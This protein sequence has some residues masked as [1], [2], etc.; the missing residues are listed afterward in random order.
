MVEQ[1]RRAGAAAQMWP[2]R[3]T[4]SPSEL[5]RATGVSR[6]TIY[7]AIQRKELPAQKIGDRVVIPVVALDRWLGPVAVLS[8]R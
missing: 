6:T 3:L 2:G 7:S 4:I 1:Q 8:A 5:A